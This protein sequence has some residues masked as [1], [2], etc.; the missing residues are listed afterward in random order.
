M[1]VCGLCNVSSKTQKEKMKKILSMLDSVQTKSFNKT[2][3]NRGNVQTNS[4]ALIIHNP[5]FFC[6]NK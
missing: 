1:V 5:V 3:E 4:F 6:P 2:S